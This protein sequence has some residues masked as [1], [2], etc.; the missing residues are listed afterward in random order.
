[1]IRVLIMFIIIIMCGSTI[2]L[3]ANKT[4][5]ITDAFG[6]TVEIPFNVRRVATGGALNQIVLM[7]GGADRIVA[8]S[9][10]VRTNSLFVKIC[11][12]IVDVVAPFGN[13]DPN[14]NIEALLASK[15]DVVFGKRDRY[16]STGLPVIEVDL[17]NS[18][19]IKHPVETV[20]HT[21]GATA[22][23]KAQHYVKYYDS[24]V[25]R[26]KKG[27]ETIS[28]EKRLRVFTAGGKDGFSTDGKNTIADCWITYAGGINVGAI[29][30]YEGLGKS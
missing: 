5:T 10:A 7:L 2:L 20:G 22:E 26:V 11:P 3:A 6:H 30:G 29:A 23:V 12:G 4:R 28:S 8:T 27:A 19:G 1:M 17:T 15:P 9:D 16:L 14:V 13:G 18:D 24:I 21:L 25:T